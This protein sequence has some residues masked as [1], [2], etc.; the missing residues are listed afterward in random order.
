MNVQNRAAN[1]FPDLAKT[2]DALQP[3]F[4]WRGGWRAGFF[5]SPRLGA[6]AQVANQFLTA[7]LG[8]LSF[9]FFPAG[10]LKLGTNFG[11]INSCFLII[12]GRGPV[13]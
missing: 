1:L 5:N 7:F 12:L 3:L 8:S 11:G 6:I 10:V 9:G 2:T 13:W 4:A